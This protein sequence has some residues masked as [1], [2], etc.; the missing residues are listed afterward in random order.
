V[1]LV[2]PNFGVL[3]QENRKHAG[4][5]YVHTLQRA[6]AALSAR[7]ADLILWPESMWP[8][9]LDRKMERDF[10]SGHPWNLRGE[11]PGRLLVGALTHRFE[12]ATPRDPMVNNSAILISAKGD[13]SGRY[14]KNHLLPFGE[15]IPMADRYPR[16]ASNLR[17]RM[18]QW[19]D[20]VPGSGGAVLRDGDLKVGVM[21]CSEDL[22]VNYGAAIARNHPNLLASVANDAWFGR[23]AAPLQ[24]LALAAF[25]A[26]EAR[27]DLVRCTN[28][29]VSGIVDAVGRVRLQGPR[30]D[31][32]PNRPKPPTLISGRVALSHMFSLGPYTIGLFPW[33]CAVVLIGLAVASR[34]RQKNA[35]IDRQQSLNPNRGLV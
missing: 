34:L 16:A 11:H 29:G 5:K 23:G 7:G 8:Y 15:A 4:F 31:V 6:N 2:Q 1:G 9:V 28:T 13:F 24:H 17:A 19:P 22:L 35:K 20:I 10:P 33:G 27:R 14:D 25:R 3:S 18:P 21:I 30:V 12:N 32:F 26:I